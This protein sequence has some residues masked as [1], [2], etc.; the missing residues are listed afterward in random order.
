MTFKVDEIFN[1]LKINNSPYL[2]N[3]FER[4]LNS[5]NEIEYNA[6]VQDL[7]KE[8]LGYSGITIN[9]F[10]TTT[11]ANGVSRQTYAGGTFGL[12]IWMTLELKHKNLGS[13]LL[14]NA[15]VE[16]SQARN[17]VTT[18]IQG[19]DGTVKEFIS[20]GDYS[21]NI[22][23][24]LFENNWDMPK[25]K[26][27]KLNRFCQV[28]DT[29]KIVHEFCNM[30]GIYDIVIQDFKFPYNPQINCVLFELNCMSDTPIELKQK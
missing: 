26:T 10:S 19:R 27:Q 14:E 6:A 12:P 5:G 25:A 21:L 24:I 29:V 1:Y 20:N 22:K 16:I 4:I 28:K 11:D 15:I 2:V 18:S 9:D 23:G 17:I 7:T 8:S 13:L 3:A 30:I